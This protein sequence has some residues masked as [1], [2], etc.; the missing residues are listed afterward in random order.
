[1]EVDHPEN[2]TLKINDQ[3]K[4]LAKHWWTF[5]NQ[6]LKSIHSDM[7]K[8]IF[9]S[10]LRCSALFSKDSFIEFMEHMMSCNVTVKIEVVTTVHHSCRGCGKI[11]QQI[12]QYFQHTI[13]CNESLFNR[14]C[15]NQ[16]G[17]MNVRPKLKAQ[18]RN[19]F[20]PYS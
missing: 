14:L 15:Q 13:S 5:Y 16:G 20:H 6:N 11:F 17:Q 7:M 8:Q 4:A 18:R 1:M 2:W 9:P 10:C 19:R 12:D 3:S